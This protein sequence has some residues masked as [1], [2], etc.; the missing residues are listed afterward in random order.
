MFNFRK[1]LKSLHKIY[2]AIPETFLTAF[3][4]M[5]KNFRL[6]TFCSDFE[7]EKISFELLLRTLN[8][9]KPVHINAM[10]YLQL[11]VYLDKYKQTN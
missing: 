6:K 5:K 4:A 8:D 7:K 11:Q 10:R 1:N 9:S 3:S 2:F